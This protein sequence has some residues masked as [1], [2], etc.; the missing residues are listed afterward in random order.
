M[1][2]QLVYNGFTQDGNNR[3]YRF[4][5]VRKQEPASQYAICVDLALFAKYH[6]P[7]QIGPIFCRQ[8]LQDALECETGLSERFRNYLAIDS[9]FAGLLAERAAREAAIAAKKPGRRP[10]RKPTVLHGHGIS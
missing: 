5:A 2:V 4:D 7:F 6:V 1:D 10:F 9:D 8:L 3:R